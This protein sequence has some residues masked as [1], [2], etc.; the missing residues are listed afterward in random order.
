MRCARCACRLAA[1]RGAV[2]AAGPGS[3]RVAL[4]DNLYRL[5]EAVKGGEADQQQLLK[6]LKVTRLA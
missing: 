4:L 2:S 5:A 1:E 3:L 6:E